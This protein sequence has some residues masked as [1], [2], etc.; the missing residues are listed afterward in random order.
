MRS[1]AS[2]QGWSFASAVLILFVLAALPAF[3]QAPSG[4]PAPSPELGK[5]A[6][7]AGNWTCTGKA[8]ESPFGPA[9]ATRAKVH[10]NKE[11]GGFWYV[12]RYEETKTAENPH[13]VIFQFLQG[14]DGT[15]KAFVMECF[16]N[17]GSHCHSTS[18]GWQDN[19]LVFTGEAAGS[20]P[21][22]PVRDTFTKTG[23]AGLEHTGEFQMDGKWVIIGHETCKRAK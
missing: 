11:I 10:V 7:F 23:D 20:G 5:L 19:K 2:K 15:A 9:H 12:G 4:P 8:E 18:A 21:A 17:F 22:T 13:P 3:S 6:F 14:Y 1:K 16:D